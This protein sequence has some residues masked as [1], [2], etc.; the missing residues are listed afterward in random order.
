M[1]DVNTYRTECLLGSEEIFVLFQAQFY[2][3]IFFPSEEK[4]QRKSHQ[5]G[6]CE[7]IARKGICNLCCSRLEAD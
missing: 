1:K 5:T 6:S 3:F 2:L 7:E 4:G